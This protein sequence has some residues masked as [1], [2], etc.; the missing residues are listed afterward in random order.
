MDVYSRNQA[1]QEE[2]N[3]VASAMAGGGLAFDI[4][5]LPVGGAAGIGENQDK[6]YGITGQSG[7]LRI[8]AHSIDVHS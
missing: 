8:T 6:R 3:R 5:T 4:G 2:L 7:R 1:L